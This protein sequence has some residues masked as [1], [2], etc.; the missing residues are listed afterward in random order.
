MELC[1]AFKA[2]YSNKLLDQG[3]GGKTPGIRAGK[4]PMGGR[5]PGGRTPGFP[6]RGG[7]TPMYGGRTPLPGQPQPQPPCKSYVTEWTELTSRWSSSECIWRTCNPGIWRSTTWIPTS[8]T[9]WVWD[10]TTT[11]RTW[12]WTRTTPSDWSG[13]EPR[14][15]VCPPTVLVTKANCVG[16]CW[17]DN[18]VVGGID[19]SV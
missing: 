6:M 18:K 14:E 5:T 7:A 9:G 16:Q 4:T 10:A 3:T 11:W 13:Y 8:S 12:V 17:L 19:C 1:N 2:Q 15:S